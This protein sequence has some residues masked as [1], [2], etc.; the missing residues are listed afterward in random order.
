[1][2]KKF[3][4]D[5]WPSKPSKLPPNVLLYVT[6]CEDL[7]YINRLVLKENCIVIPKTFQ[8]EMKI[9]LHNGH[10]GIV[11]IKNC[12]RE[13]FWLGINSDIKNTVRTYINI[14]VKNIIN[15]SGV[16]HT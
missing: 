2:V 6:Y 16:K 4:Q 15:N 13:M 11:K 5:V 8:N 14:D 1:M 10:F 7:H 12:A 3:I 9:L